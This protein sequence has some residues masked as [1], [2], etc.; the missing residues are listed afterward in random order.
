MALHRHKRRVDRDSPHPGRP[1]PGPV[2]PPAPTNQG[3]GRHIPR[4]ASVPLPKPP[5]APPGPQGRPQ[6][7]LP[8]G[9]TLAPPS[10]PAPPKTPRPKPQAVQD[11]KATQSR[12]K[13]IKAA[14]GK[15]SP[16]LRNRLLLKRTKA[17]KNKLA[18]QTAKGKDTS[19]TQALLDKTLA[20]RKRLRKPKPGAHVTPPAHA[21]PKSGARRAERRR[22]ARL[23]RSAGKTKTSRSMPIGRPGDPNKGRSPFDI[24][25]MGSFKP[26]EG[27]KGAGSG[28]KR[29]PGPPRTVNRAVKSVEQRKARRLAVTSE[30]KARRRARRQARRQRRRHAA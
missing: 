10:T 28:P 30:K 12:V 14:G 17:A 16:K 22:A 19:G 9:V 18:R 15:V 1:S 29:L 21:A 11:F 26:T 2:R 8:K 23:R 13:K 5:S 27:S 3:R 24:T 20:R 25:T 4:T 7:L 6:T